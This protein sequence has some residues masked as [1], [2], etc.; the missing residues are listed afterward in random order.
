M[1]IKNI[2]FMVIIFLIGTITVNAGSIKFN[3]T[4]I[5]PNANL[6]SLSCATYNESTSTLTLNNCDASAY[7]IS[8]YNMDSVTID[9]VGTS[10]IDSFTG[11]ASAI[12]TMDTDLIISGSGTLNL[13][14]LINVDGDLT[15]NDVAINF[16]PNTDSNNIY[17]NYHYAVDADKVSIN[18]AQINLGYT[19]SNNKN[20]V[21]PTFFLYCDEDIEINNTQISGI[22]SEFMSHDSSPG[23]S[24][25]TINNSDIDVAASG[26]KFDR[27]ATITDSTIDFTYTEAEKNILSNTQKYNDIIS[28]ET[29][30]FSLDN[31]TLTLKDTDIYGGPLTV[32]NGSTLNVEGGEVQVSGAT[33]NNSKV[34]FKNTRLVIMGDF[35]LLNNAEFAIDSHS[36]NDMVLAVMQAKLTVDNSKLTMKN[37]ATYG[38]YLF[39]SDLVVKNGIVDVTDVKNPDIQIQTPIFMVRYQ[40]KNPVTLEGDS[41][42]IEGGKVQ[43]AVVPDGA[44]T[45]YF[46]YFAEEEIEGIVDAITRI[47]NGDMS[48]AEADMAAIDK[49]ASRVLIHSSSLDNPTQATITDIIKNIPKTGLFTIAGVVLGIGIISYGTYLI[50]KS[51]K[52][53]LN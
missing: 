36:N 40:D 30:S 53:E 20:Y 23:N 14:G 43:K 3:D 8:I 16:M 6:A 7:K 51:N 29:V 42:V 38:I 49:M 21:I 5:Y 2:I 52:K 19:V 4:E 12:Y 17:S 22:A 50:I 44:N 32:K 39:D 11:P 24:T 33:I 41:K 18:G 47:D 13:N 25:I 46:Y 10:T 1:K 31:S 9:V 15:I 26:T 37:N 35:S 27:Y 45:M 28:E 48:H 34:K